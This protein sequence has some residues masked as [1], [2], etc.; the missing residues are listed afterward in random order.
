MAD[1]NEDGRV[2]YAD[3]FTLAVTYG[4]KIGMPS[5]N[6]K[7]D[8]NL[9]G[10]IDYM[11]CSRLPLNTVTQRN[12]SQAMLLLLVEQSI[13]LLLKVTRQLL[14]SVSIKRVFPSLS[15]SLDLVER[16]TTQ[17]LGFQQ[18]SWFRPS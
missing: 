14:V 6:M 13:I 7:A 1:T 18:L 16:L 12:L 5:Y 8:F 9:D 2:D 4:Y 3:L 10:R 11:V 15:T 17:G